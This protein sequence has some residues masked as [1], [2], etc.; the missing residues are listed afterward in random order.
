MEGVILTLIIIILV[1]AAVAVTL[2]VKFYVK[3]Q[4]NMAF[5]R[6]GLGGKRVIIDGGAVVFPV[7]QQVKWISLETVK[8]KVLRANKEG[9]ITKDKFRVDIGAEFYMRVE[10][11]SENVETA[12]RSLGDKSL[13]T[14]S[15]RVIMEEKLVSAVRAVSAEKTLI[16]LHENRIQLSRDIKES[17]KET[18]HLN[19]FTLED[20]SVFHLDQTRKD[21]LDPNNIFDAEGLKQI[22]AQTS[23]RMK[24]R[25]EIERNTE[26]AINQKDVEAVK[27]KLKLGQ[28]K[29]FATAEQMRE[30]E[31]FKVLKKSEIEQFRFQQERSIRSGEIE[32]EKS[33]RESELA[34]EAYIIQKEQKKEQTDIEK[35]M[36]LEIARLARD[37]GIL[38]KEKEKIQEERDRI[39]AE[40]KRRVSLQNLLTV[41]KE[42]EAQR[43][44][45]IASIEAEKGV[46]VAE[47]KAKAA[48]QSALAILREG[49]AEAHVKLKHREAENVLDT[50]LIVKDIAE[51]FIKNAPTIFRELMEP[52]R[53]IESIRV[54]NIGTNSGVMGGDGRDTVGSVLGAILSSSA[55]IPVLRE[56][57]NF[58]KVDTEK[59]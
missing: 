14:E 48:E 53:N 57:L 29:E 5:I 39:E 26:V 47:L 23:Q 34:K 27:L 7:V 56:I 35:E 37:I 58:S 46:E 15:L 33:I 25:N 19:G 43:L 30:V 6:T 10:P 8:L 11:K 21:Q 54:L 32:K 3:T 50:K 44:R 28:D 42:A 55:V 36:A 4:P 18:L 24:E 52:A 41:E 13:S 59:V 49:E 16:E 45:K 1:I 31:T 2:A 17:L 9:V 12:S 22:T 38:Q 40:A 20:V 51:E